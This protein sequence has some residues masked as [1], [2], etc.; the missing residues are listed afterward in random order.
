MQRGL[1]NR[2]REMVPSQEGLL[3][4]ITL[5]YSVSDLKTEQRISN[6]GSRRSRTLKRLVRICRLMLSFSSIRSRRPGFSMLWE[7][8][9]ST[10]PKGIV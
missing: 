9:F 2:G 8:R 1:T 7:R 4:V 3:S 5:S 10:V 6:D